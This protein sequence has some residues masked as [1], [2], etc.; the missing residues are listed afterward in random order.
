MGCYVTRAG[1][2]EARRVGGR[3][4]V[5]MMDALGISLCLQRVLAFVARKRRL[6]ILL[7]TVEGEW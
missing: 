2:R 5:R 6:V 7:K 3:V 1:G 4:G